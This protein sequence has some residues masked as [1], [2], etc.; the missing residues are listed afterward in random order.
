MIDEKNTR[1]ISFEGNMLKILTELF[2]KLNSEFLSNGAL[3]KYTAES[4]I[5]LILGEILE[6]LKRAEKS[7]EEQGDIVRQVISYINAH[8]DKALSLEDLAAEFFISKYHLLHKFKEHTKTT[9][10]QY[11][12]MKKN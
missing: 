8:I 6:G 1:R 4:C 9:V 10:H 3:T 2:D 11:I 12:L 7:A 5:I